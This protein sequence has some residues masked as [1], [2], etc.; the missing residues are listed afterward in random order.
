M[1]NALPLQTMHSCGDKV[2]SF[3]FLCDVPC[4]TQ[5]SSDSSVSLVMALPCGEEDASRDLEEGE[6]DETEIWF[7]II[8]TAVLQGLPRCSLCLSIAGPITELIAAV[9]LHHC[10]VQADVQAPP[11]WDADGEEA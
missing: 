5:T 10:H 7:H 1:E 9:L 11:R 6:V 4:P 3:S 8:G 2:D